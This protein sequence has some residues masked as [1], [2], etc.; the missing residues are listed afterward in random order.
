[1]S[2][3]H[4]VRAAVAVRRSE[5]RRATP[6]GSPFELA[7]DVRARLIRCCKSKNRKHKR[8]GSSGYAKQQNSLVC[9][10]HGVHDDLQRKMPYQLT[11]KA[12]GSRPCMAFLLRL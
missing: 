12:R 6:H 3:A 10:K 5:L 4:L 11:W 1:V 8:D 2:I 7:L 9:E